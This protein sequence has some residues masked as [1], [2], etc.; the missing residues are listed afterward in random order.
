MKWRKASLGLTMRGRQ[1][2]FP[3]R[4]SMTLSYRKGGTTGK[5][6]FSPKWIN[7]S[8]LLGALGRD[9][10][11]IY[12]EYCHKLLGHHI[13]LIIVNRVMS[14]N[15]GFGFRPL[16]SLFVS[17]VPLSSAER[18]PFLISPISGACAASSHFWLRIF[19]SSMLYCC[20]H[21]N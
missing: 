9:R 4:H 13:R 8:A 19:L 16:A 5:A 7:P 3:A 18:L 14:S 12:V 2:C 11:E 6:L 21:W 17:P 10:P 1:Y 20:G 15:L